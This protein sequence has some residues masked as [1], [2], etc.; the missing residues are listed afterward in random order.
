MHSY[1][2]SVQRL[3]SLA[4][5]L[6]TSQ[7]CLLMIHPLFMHNQVAVCTPGRMIDLLKMKACT[8]RRATYLVFDEADRM[9][10][11]GFEPQVGQHQNLGRA[12][13]Y[14]SP[15]G[16]PLFL[17]FQRSTDHHCG[18]PDRFLIGKLLLAMQ[19][20]SI[21]G[22]VRPDR[23]TLLFSATMP[24]K[25]EALVR[26]A[27]T[28]PIRIS[29]GAVGWATHLVPLQ[30]SRTARHQLIW[31]SCCAAGEPMRTSSRLW[32]CALLLYQLVLFPGLQDAGVC[33]D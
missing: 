21:L 4:S 16:H 13:L 11:M 3:Y 17:K 30:W 7:R 5:R 23:Q 24:R 20:R 33:P 19:V 26:D 9:F 1:I 18:R 31:M 32:R 15:P 6:L 27:L 12:P 10:D 28:A 29:I 14:T 22:Q 25:V 8:M 2:V